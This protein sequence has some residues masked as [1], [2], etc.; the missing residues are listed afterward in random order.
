MYQVAIDQIYMAYGSMLSATKIE[1]Q[2][3]KDCKML[4]AILP[5]NSDPNI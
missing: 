3:R 1:D 2:I 4:V 5:C